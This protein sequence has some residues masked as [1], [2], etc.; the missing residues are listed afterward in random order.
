MDED[1]AIKIAIKTGKVIIGS[2]RSIDSI[3]R[4]KARLV[5]KAANCPLKISEDLKYYSKLV[6]ITIHTYKGSSLD[7]G[8]VCGKPFMISTIA[9]EEAGDSE[10]LKLS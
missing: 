5:I 7:L 4:N 1:T 10:I 2:K 9:I 6:N 3:I 8:F